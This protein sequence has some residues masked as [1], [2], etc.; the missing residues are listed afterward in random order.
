[1]S[2]SASS[3]KHRQEVDVSNIQQTHPVNKQARPVVLEDVKRLIFIELW[4]QL[5]SKC[6]VIPCTVLMDHSAL[7]DSWQAE[8]CRRRE[9]E[10]KTAGL[11]LE[12]VPV[13]KSRTADTVGQLGSSSQ[14]H[15][16][17]TASMHQC[18]RS[19]MMTQS[20]RHWG[21]RNI[22]SHTVYSRS[23]MLFWA[24]GLRTILQVSRLQPANVTSETHA[25]FYLQ[26][27]ED[28]VCLAALAPHSTSL[29][30]WGVQTIDRASAVACSALCLSITL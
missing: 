21:D 12:R 29:C 20:W 23:K 15:I 7:G 14:I 25:A 22:R 4:L 17:A 30:S 28:L 24:F 9:E 2:P 13:V 6:E 10:K 19:S 18:L 27:T 8:K 16:F 1:M 5:C 11:I 3:G 26:H